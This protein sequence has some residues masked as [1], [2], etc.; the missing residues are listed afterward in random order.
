MGAGGRCDDALRTIVSCALGKFRE[1]LPLWL[2]EV[3]Q[4]NSM[5][6]FACLICRCDVVFHC[7]LYPLLEYGLSLVGGVVFC[8]S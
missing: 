3:H 2:L 1:I 4:C 6:R 7:S 8:G 5:G